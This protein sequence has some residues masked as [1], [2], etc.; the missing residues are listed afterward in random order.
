[1]YSRT[2]DVVEGLTSAR[3][4]EVLYPGA[5]TSTKQ[6]P[7]GILENSTC[8]VSLVT[9]RT[10]TFLR[11]QDTFTVAFS[12]IGI[13]VGSRTLTYILEFDGSMLTS[14]STPRKLS[15][16]A[17]MGAGWLWPATDPQSKST[18]AKGP[19]I[20]QTGNPIFCRIR[21]DVQ[22]IASSSGF[23]VLDARQRKLYIAP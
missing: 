16:W 11:G 8:A 22:I 6:S 23:V 12:V 14:A 10:S 19:A 17:A 5:L 13:P 3:S 20:R 4:R 21:A 2:D 9:P 15:A 1:M 18:R 7:A